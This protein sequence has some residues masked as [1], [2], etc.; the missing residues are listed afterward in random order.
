[1]VMW[2]VIAIRNSVLEQVEFWM[3]ICDPKSCCQ[4]T[5]LEFA[6]LEI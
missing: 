5:S 4:V 3:P 2:V 1:M 6:G